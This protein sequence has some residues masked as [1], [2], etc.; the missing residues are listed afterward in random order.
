M[1]LDEFRSR[2]PIFRRR[3]YVNSCSQGALSTNVDD[4]L[5]S[6]MDSWHECGSA[7]EMRVGQVEFLRERFAGSIG[8]GAGGIA[9]VPRCPA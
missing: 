6:Y 1:H 9:G 7:W 8:A 4:A 3:V 5:R 2:F